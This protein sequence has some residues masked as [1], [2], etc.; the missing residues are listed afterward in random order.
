LGISDIKIPVE[1]TRSSSKEEE[2]LIRAAADS[3][4]TFP[5]ANVFRLVAQTEVAKLS[6]MTA[7]QLALLKFTLKQEL[8]DVL[9]A[10]DIE[11]YLK[12]LDSLNN[13]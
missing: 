12:K 7:S 3:N 4:G 13:Q 5:G 11:E 6:E 1:H 9:H 10:T 8:S 2:Q